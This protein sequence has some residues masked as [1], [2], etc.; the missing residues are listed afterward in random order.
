MASS[1]N[2]DSFQ[3]RSFY[4]CLSRKQA[5]IVPTYIVEFDFEGKKGKTRFFLDD[6][7]GW[8]CSLKEFFILLAG[9]DEEPENDEINFVLC[10][11][12]KDLF[13]TETFYPLTFLLTCHEMVAVLTDKRL[14]KAVDIDLRHH[15]SRM[16]ASGDFKDL[17]QFLQFERVNRDFEYTKNKVLLACKDPSTDSIDKACFAV[18]IYHSEHPTQTDPIVDLSKPDLYNHD[19]YKLLRLMILVDPR[20]THVSSPSKSTAKRERERNDPFSPFSLFTLGKKS[21][22]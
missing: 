13:D 20:I 11:I 7:R 21:R 2:E 17:E 6:S 19:V 15:I 5:Y 16:M 10:Q 12:F 18:S 22:K 14:K 4:R 8:L 1:S 3:I 9:E